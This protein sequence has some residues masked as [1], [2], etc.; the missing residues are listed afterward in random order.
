MVQLN[1]CFILD[2]IN[3]QPTFKANRVQQ[4]QASNLE[5]RYIP[6]HINPADFASRGL[7]PSQ[8][9]N[10]WNGPTFLQNEEADWSE[11]LVPTASNIISRFFSFYMRIL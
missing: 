1:D 11:N 10:W 5:W 6:T 3:K 7:T 4:I 9:L 8:L 2:T